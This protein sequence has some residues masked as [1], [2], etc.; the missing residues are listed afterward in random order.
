MS[1]IFNSLHIGYSGLNAAQI[2][3]DTTSHN[4]T[5][6]DAEGYT[7]QRVVTAATTPIS[8]ASGN[9]G[10]G[11]EVVDIS[12]V[13]D[14]FVFKRF[15]EVSGD[16]E[17]SDFM[18]S[19]LQTL[20]TYFPE[21]DDV[22]IKSD[23]KA[24][25]S[26]WQTYADNP[27]ND[28]IKLAL[29]KQAQKVASGIQEMQSK[30][31]TLQKSVND[32]LLPNIEEV[33]ILAKELASI[34]AKIGIAESAGAYT[35]NDLRDKRSA[36]EEKM[37]KLIGANAMYGQISSNIRVDGSLNEPDG[38]YTL[39][40]NG[41]NI[42]DGS[43]YHPIMITDHKNATGF[44]EIYY[45]RQDGTLL[46]MT[47]SVTG[48]RVGAML[49][50]RGRELIDKNK[51]QPGDGVLQNVV[52][53][54]NAFASRL[55]ESTNNLYAQS[56]TTVMESNSFN[57]TPLDPLLSANTKGINKGSFDIV[58]YDI[59]GKEIARRNININEETRFS[60]VAG[61]NSIEGQIIATND[62][63]GDGNAT[64]DVNSFIHY[65]FLTNA[66]GTAK[67]NFSMDPYQADKGYRFA[68]EDKLQNSSYASGSNFAGAMGMSR[69]F[70]GNDAK[71]INLTSELN[72]NPTKI[73]SG[74]TGA[75]GDNR[76]ALKMLQQQFE[77]YDYSVDY[78][79]K[80]NSTIYGMFDIISTNVGV[81]ANQAI[82][83]ND[84]IKAKYNAI[85][86]EYSTVSKVSVDEELTNLIRYQ[87]SYGAASKIIT[88]IDQMM[89]TLL[90]L[91]Q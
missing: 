16:K 57:I 61:S 44:Y 40:V 22:G 74:F 55:I 28:A 58:V 25:Y 36:I 68:I 76:L 49:E 72:N 82:L 62:D 80:F 31:S 9:Y 18:K 42:V 13:F 67:L 11:T 56:A 15:T 89:Q 10:N 46:P 59:D 86:L 37:A 27:D 7:R 70:D 5:N 65:N 43:S 35:A 19:T 47:E 63:N 33:N 81:S 53:Q 32:Q 69:F 52:N 79:T 64:N 6:A 4:I 26:M 90:G 60:G 30:I 24:Y 84:T 77:K 41:F 8:S 54:M 73:A 21:V 50:L 75:S 78:S 23:L 66:D 20:S 14:S 45:E 1:S 34:N 12:R 17:Y 39:S 38:G 85:E 71:S 87:T 48:G 88:T 3:V 2:G 51:S 83:A 91:K 29:A